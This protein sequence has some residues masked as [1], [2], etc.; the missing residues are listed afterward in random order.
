MEEAMNKLLMSLSRAT[1][2]AGLLVAGSW[3]V[4]A[5]TDDWITVARLPKVTNCRSAESNARPGGAY[6]AFTICWSAT[7]VW[8]KASANDTRDRDNRG[9]AAVIRYFV[10]INGERRGHWRLAEIGRAHV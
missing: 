4:N 2:L 6:A 5:E 3:V 1:A 7:N 10:R 9:A 8:V